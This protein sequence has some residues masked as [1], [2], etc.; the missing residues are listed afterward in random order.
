[1]P[2][3]VPVTSRAYDLAAVL[4]G[5]WYCVVVQK[6]LP[7]KGHTASIYGHTASFYGRNLPFSSARY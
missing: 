4:T 5:R 6:A 3:H 2:V 1:M 7:F